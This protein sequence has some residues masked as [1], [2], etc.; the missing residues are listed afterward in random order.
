MSIVIHFFLT[1]PA[2]YHIKNLGFFF[3][4]FF[5][6]NNQ[7]YV[8]E[9]DEVTSKL[10][11]EEVDRINY[12]SESG[13]ATWEDAR[14]MLV[15]FFALWSSV[16]IIRDQNFGSFCS[17]A[18]EG[19]TLPLKVSAI[20]ICLKKNRRKR[21]GLRKLL[22]STIAFPFCRT[23]KESILVSSCY[24]FHTIWISRKQWLTQFLL[25]L[26]AKKKYIRMKCTLN[27][28]TK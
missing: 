3:L 21:L 20:Y 8:P 11:W 15:P 13:V 16:Y 25:S 26:S 12:V 10:V 19:C 24:M 6:W 1:T 23:M 5:F 7:E 4:F 9:Y 22:L 2:S 27:F 28:R 14:I 17:W 18:W